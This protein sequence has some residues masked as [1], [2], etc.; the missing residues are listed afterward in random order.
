[1]EKLVQVEEQGK[2]FLISIQRPK[3]L[4]AINEQVCQ[5][6]QTAFAQACQSDCSVIILKGDDQ[7][8]AA[9]ADVAPMANASVQAAEQYATVFRECMQQV[10]HCDLPVIAYLRGYVLGGG[11]ELALACDF[12]IA[13]EEVQLGLPEINLGIMPGA[14]GTQ[15]LPRLIGL[16]K[17]KEMIYLGKLVP[18]EQALSMNLVD[19]VYKADQVWEKTL[20]L[21]QAIAKKPRQSLKK[22]KQA[23][24]SC[25]NLFLDQGAAYET[26]LFVQLFSTEDQ[27][28]GMQAFINKRKPQFQNR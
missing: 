5:E 19:Y 10:Y 25:Y 12:R 21:A 23:I 14:G 8:F 3:V 6:L 11:L 17:A 7:N 2:V 1:M 16:P 26:N 27:K 4:N 13:S 24:Q 28:E 9:G 18:A 22:A 20:E 15:R